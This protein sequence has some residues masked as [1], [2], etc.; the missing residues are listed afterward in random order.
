MG[1][2]D[3]CILWMDRWMDIW[4]CRGIYW[5]TVHGFMVLYSKNFQIVVNFKFKAHGGLVIHR[6]LTEMEWEHGK[7]DISVKCQAWMDGCMCVYV[8]GVVLGLCQDKN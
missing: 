3:G 4:M 5:F 1:L 2:G 7:M 6:R 8:L